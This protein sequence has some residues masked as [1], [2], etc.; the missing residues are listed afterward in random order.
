MYLDV[1]TSPEHL[2]QALIDK[3]VTD[4][5]VRSCYRINQNVWSDD[6]GT[7]GQPNPLSKFFLAKIPSLD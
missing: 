3:S 5:S 2:I 6:T 7:E 4:L 1:Y